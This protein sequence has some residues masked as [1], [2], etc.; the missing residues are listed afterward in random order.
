M[1]PFHRAFSTINQDSRSSS[2]QMRV[3]H[4]DS[5][6]LEYRPK[7]SQSASINKGM[8]AV[9]RRI[10]QRVDLELQSDFNDVEGCNA[11]SGTAL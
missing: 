6:L 2:G 3:A 11:E 4:R 5:L 8:V 7:G 1:L 9:T 10:G